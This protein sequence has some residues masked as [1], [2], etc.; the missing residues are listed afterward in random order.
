IRWEFKNVRL[1]A[2]NY[3]KAGFYAYIPDV[4][5]GDLLPI[6][7]LQSVEPPLK[8]REQAG[9]VDRAKSMATVATTLPPWLLKHRE[10]VAKSL[11]DGF[12][13]AVRMIPGTDKVGAIEGGS[14]AIL[15]AYGPN[16]NGEGAAIGGVDAAV[17]CHPSLVSIPADFEPVTKP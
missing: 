10:G 16:K 15:E 12:I 7:F 3:A 6:E 4:H 11:I 2:E 17:A 8:D 5:Q 13:N 9:M 14:Y 1:L